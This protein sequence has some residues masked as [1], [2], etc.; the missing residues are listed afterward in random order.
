MAK[1]GM[2]LFSSMRAGCS[3]CHHGPDLGR[4]THAP[5]GP[6]GFHNLGLYDLDGLGAYPADAIGLASVSGL[7][8]D[9]GKFRTPTLR[10]VAVTGPYFHDG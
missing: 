10:N 8:G 3:Q 6:S 7:P 5:L 1:Q 9:M 2:S 4:P